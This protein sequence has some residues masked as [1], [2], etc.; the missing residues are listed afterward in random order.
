[1]FLTCLEKIAV[2][3]LKWTT[4]TMPNGFINDLK[5][6]HTRHPEVNRKFMSGKF[7]INQ[8]GKPFSNIRIDQ[9]HEQNNKLVKIDDGAVDIL[10]TDNSA[11]TRWMVARPEIADMVNN[12]RLTEND[13]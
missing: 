10:L 8:S 13:D 4:F 6:L 11:L 1:M 2:W 12:F 5:T 3:M 9:A 7:T